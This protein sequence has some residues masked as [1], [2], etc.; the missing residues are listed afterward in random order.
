MPHLLYEVCQ[1]SFMF[2]F[3]SFFGSSC[4]PPFILLLAELHF[5]LRTVV[6][7]FRARLIVCDLCLPSP[8]SYPSPLPQ[9]PPSLPP[10]P[11]AWDVLQKP[12][13]AASSSGASSSQIVFCIYNGR[14]LETVKS[15]THNRHVTANT[16]QCSC[17]DGRWLNDRAAAEGLGS[18]PASWLHGV[19]PLAT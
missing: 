15:M 11:A 9:F 1:F 19:R 12:G 13:R 18:P 14:R 7:H 8:S 10:F 2:S 3:L 16:L 4:F 5:V 6:T 17:R